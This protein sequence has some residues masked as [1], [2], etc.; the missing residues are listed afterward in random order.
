MG[1]EI[2]CQAKIG[3][4]TTTGKLYLESSALLFRGG[5]RLKIPFAELGDV[6]SKG[7]WVTL[8]HNGG[9]IAFQLGAK[10]ETWADKIRNPPTRLQKM[11]I[12]PGMVC[13]LIGPDPDALL[14]ELNASGVSVETPSGDGRID[15]VIFVAESKSDLDALKAAEKHITQPGSIWVVFRKGIQEITESDVMVA[16]KAAELV[17]PKTC[18]FSETRTALQCVIPVSRRSW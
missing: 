8:T 1:Q 5:T 17:I 10:A 11:D 16:A 2:V 13:G 6:R 14:A 9:N 3:D 4:Q 7:G 18:S 12:E 15:S